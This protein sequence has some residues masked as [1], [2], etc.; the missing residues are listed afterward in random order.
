MRI[1]R[2]TDA[3]SCGPRA[4]QIAFSHYN[5]FPKYSKLLKL[6]STNENGTEVEMLESA[7][8]AVGLKATSFDEHASSKKIKHYTDKQIPVVVMWYAGVDSHVS[9]AYKV[10]DT[11]IYLFDPSLHLYTEPTIMIRRTM[12]EK[13]WRKHPQSRWIMAV[14]E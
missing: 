14:Y 2:Q 6:C 4:L 11:F 13:C 8:T 7:T 12:L 3:F 1:F 10:D 5:I 9:V